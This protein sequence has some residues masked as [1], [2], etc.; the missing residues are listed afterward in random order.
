M[1]GAEIESVEARRAEVDARQE[2]VSAWLAE[3]GLEALFLFDPALIAWMIAGRPWTDSVDAERPG[4]FLFVTRFARCLVAR[5]D[6]SVAVLQTELDRLGFQLKEYSWTESAAALVQ[7]LA[8]GRKAAADGP[9]FGLP[10]VRPSLIPLT[11]SLS[12]RDVRLFRRLAVRTAGALENT[13]RAL[14]PGVSR[15]QLQGE[16][17]RQLRMAPV[18]PLSIEIDTDTE[19][20]SAPLDGPTHHPIRGHAVVS[21]VAT[22]WGLTYAASRTVAFGVGEAAQR[23]AA[24]HL[25]ALEIGATLARFTATGVSPAKLFDIVRRQY[26]RHDAEFDWRL[27]PQGAFLGHVRRLE[28]LVPGDEAPLAMGSAVVW[29][30]VIGRAKVTDVALALADKVQTVHSF[31]D[32]PTVPV[33]VGELEFKRPA[34]LDLPE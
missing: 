18:E 19:P 10:D 31:A 15:A 33:R 16:L 34:I 22:C 13:L 3:H 9:R 11:R 30:P 1:G 4:A 20:E 8:G 27:R 21:V 6:R 26:E 7:D 24:D 17:A 23:L 28:P 32:W 12:D 5:N 2:K 25:K 14:V 29:Q